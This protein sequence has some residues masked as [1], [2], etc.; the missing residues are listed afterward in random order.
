[1]P[2]RRRSPK[3]ISLL[4]RAFATWGLAVATIAGAYNKHFPPAPAD[5]NVT[6]S[7]GGLSVTFNIAWGAA[8]VGVADRNV[9]HGL[10]IVDANDV[11]RELQPCQFLMLTIGGRKQII[12][13]P[14][15]AGALGNQPY[16]RHPKGDVIPEQG[17]PVIRWSA[18]RDRFQ[19]T[20]APL[21]YDTGKSSN[22]VYVEDVRIDP[23]GVA[24]FHYA[25]YDHE[26]RT[27]SMIAI[28]ATLYTDRTGTFMYPLLSPYGRAG[29]SLRRE[30]MP[31][32][33]VKVVTGAP[34]WP[35][36]PLGSKG[37]IANIDSGDDLGI[38][39]TTPVGLRESYGVYTN[40]PGVYDVSDRP[41]LAQTFAAAYM[42]SRPGDIYS[43]D[44]S[45]LVSTAER[46]PALISRQP[47]AVFRIVRKGH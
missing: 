8:V 40:T 31:N 46:G 39:Y 12:L 15:Q 16:Y 14:T 21:D 42:T 2:L 11:G 37:W 34:N 24:R 1:M 17:S 13:N 35:Q 6:I 28:V 36:G 22:W 30:K 4:C 25:F 27:Y 33:P 7:N 10:S 19:A 18:S 23:R 47:A 32:W 43:V 20:I 3:P 41:P 9:G 5:R 38:F 26:P 44:F 45:V 29:A